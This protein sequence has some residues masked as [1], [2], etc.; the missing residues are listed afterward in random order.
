M[1]KDGLLSDLNYPIKCDTAKGQRS[2]EAN[3]V[4]LVSM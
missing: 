1:T 4:K 2:A 3:T